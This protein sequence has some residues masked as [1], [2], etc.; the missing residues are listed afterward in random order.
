MKDLSILNLILVVLMALII[1]HEI[2]SMRIC[3]DFG[4]SYDLDYGRCYERN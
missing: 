1:G 2:G 3:K 4:K